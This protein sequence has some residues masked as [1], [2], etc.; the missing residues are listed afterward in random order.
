MGERYWVKRRDWK[1]HVDVLVIDGYVDEPGLLGVPPYISP[2]PRMLVGVADELDLT[3]EY[4]TV[5]E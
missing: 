3:W 5:D 1:E 4:V 2:E